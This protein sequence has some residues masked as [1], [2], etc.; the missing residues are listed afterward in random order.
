MMWNFWAIL[1]WPMTWDIG[2]K[3]G[4]KLTWNFDRTTAIPP[5]YEI[6]ILVSPTS[7]L[8]ATPNNAASEHDHVWKIDESS[9]LPLSF[10]RQIDCCCCYFFIMFWQCRRVFLFVTGI[11]IKWQLDF[12]CLWHVLII[13]LYKWWSGCHANH[14][15]LDNGDG[16][17]WHALPGE[18]YDQWQTSHHNLFQTSSS[19]VEELPSLVF[20]NWFYLSEIQPFVVLGASYF[21]PSCCC[22]MFAT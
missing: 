11:L 21:A 4:K 2:E 16:L 13:Q 18:E 1:V 19:F 14:R 8:S 20:W 22:T 3:M 10:L 12:P 7:I 15:S 5:V 9:N 17:P 6:D